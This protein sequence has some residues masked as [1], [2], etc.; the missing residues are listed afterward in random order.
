MTRFSTR[1]APSSFLKLKTGN[2][3]SWWVICSHITVPVSTCRLLEICLHIKPHNVPVSGSDGVS[4]NRLHSTEL[5][6]E[7]L[8]PGLNILH[9]NH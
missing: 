1:P 5:H 4:S 8:T 3:P 7:V 6:A 2:G 9:Q